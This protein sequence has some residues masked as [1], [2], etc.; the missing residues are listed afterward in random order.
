MIKYAAVEVTFAEIPDEINLCLSISN[1]AGMCR[2][3]HS[4]AL[5][6]DVGISVIENIVAEIERHKGI[7]CVCFLGEARKVPG[8]LAIWSAIVKLIREKFP[9]LKI[10][11]YSGR[12]DVE[13]EMWQMFDYIKIGPYI[14]EKGPLENPN[15]N[16]KLFKIDR[17]NNQKIDITHLFWRKSQ[18]DK[19]RIK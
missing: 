9:R 18:E 14:E 17:K 2:N 12:E 19:K 7:S 5:R 16:Q 10:A 3:C 6:G 11:M 15:T 4:P 13:D 1:C 8:A